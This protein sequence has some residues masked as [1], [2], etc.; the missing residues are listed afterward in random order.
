VRARCFGASSLPST[1]AL[2]DDDLGSDVRQFT[3]LPG[4]HLVSH[5][6]EVALHSV[7]THRN[8][9]DE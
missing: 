8:A 4:L 3:S 2:V 1:N 5:R 7:H 6:L 9:I